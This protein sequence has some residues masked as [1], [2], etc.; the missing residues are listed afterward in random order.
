MAEAASSLTRAA[1]WASLDLPE[2]IKLAPAP[3]IFENGWGVCVRVVM[4]VGPLEG[5]PTSCGGLALGPMGGSPMSPLP[6]LRKSELVQG[7]VAREK[8]LGATACASARA[9]AGGRVHS[10]C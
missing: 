8:S 6:L 1:F 4:C 10:V 3:L 2:E 7:Q 9:L 5:C